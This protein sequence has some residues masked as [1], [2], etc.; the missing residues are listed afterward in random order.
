[1]FACVRFLLLLF[2]YRCVCVCESV[3]EHMSR[4][5]YG[6]CALGYIYSEIHRHVYRYTKMSIVCVRRFIRPAIHA[7]ALF[8]RHRWGEGGHK[9][10]ITNKRKHN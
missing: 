1:M 2:V 9:G 4:I 3:V 10:Q 6:L 8:V 5:M 7:V